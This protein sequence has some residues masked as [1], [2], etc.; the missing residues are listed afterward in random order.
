MTE[1]I[2]SISSVVCPWCP[3]KG[4]PAFQAAQ[5]QINLSLTT[6]NANSDFTNQFTDLKIVFGNP[7]LFGT[8]GDEPLRE[9]LFPVAPPEVARGFT[10]RRTC[11]NSP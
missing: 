8:E 7:A 11:C 1:A 3:G 6:G 4:L 9:V 5:P 2:R 10:P